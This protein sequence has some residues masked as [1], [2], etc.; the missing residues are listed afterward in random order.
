MI[1]YMR[2]FH[3]GTHA[4]FPT[5]TYRSAELVAAAVELEELGYPANVIAERLGVKWGTIVTARW[6]LRRREE[7][8]K[9]QLD[10]EREEEKV[11]QISSA[12]EIIRRLR[13]ARIPEGAHGVTYALYA[14]GDSTLYRVALCSTWP[15]ES[16]S[17]L[18]NQTFLLVTVGSDT[19]VIPKP[20]TVDAAW[21]PGLFIAKFSD[22]YLG[23]WPAIRALLAALRW[24]PDT[25]RSTEFSTD[26]WERTAYLA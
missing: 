14:P 10:R 21:T 16:E 20:R 11:K 12:G 25:D 6:R 23:W 3:A 2:H 7:Q 5:V 22:D 17:E 13:S 9:N 4:D 1:C 24:T 18:P 26:D 8:R 19:I 15:L